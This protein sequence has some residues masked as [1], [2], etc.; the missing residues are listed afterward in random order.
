MEE[1][2]F[3]KDRLAKLL[4][5]GLISGIIAAGVNICY[6]YLHESITGFSIPEVINLGSVAI[7][8]VIP[9]IFAGLLYFILRRSMDKSKALKVFVGIVVVA[10]L[11]SFGGPLASELPDGTPTPD[12][13]AGLTIPMH[14]IAP[15]IYII[16]LVRSVPKN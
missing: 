3:Q 12:E 9:G 16:M 2:Q 4:T 11:L 13:F 8:S 7:S 15:F 10:A 14:I 6:M 1:N 5:V